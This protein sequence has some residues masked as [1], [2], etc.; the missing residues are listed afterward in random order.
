[1]KGIYV[2]NTVV[3]PC[4]WCVNIHVTLHVLPEFLEYVAEAVDLFDLQT[5]FFL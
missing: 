4:T 2:F 5:H 1:M 3:S